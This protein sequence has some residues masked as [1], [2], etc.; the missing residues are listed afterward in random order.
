MSKAVLRSTPSILKLYF[1]VLMRLAI[2]VFILYRLYF[3]LGYMRIEMPKDV[4]QHLF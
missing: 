3:Y 1:F 4:Y 2:Y